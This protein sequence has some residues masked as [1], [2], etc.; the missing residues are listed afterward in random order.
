MIAPHILKAKTAT[1]T[2][3]YPDANSNLL[4]A[5]LMVNPKLCSQ[6]LAEFQRQHR[7]VFYGDLVDYAIGDTHDRETILNRILYTTPP[8][9]DE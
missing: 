6:Y 7:V 4:L 1:R 3:V 5:A 9:W 8:E 2:H